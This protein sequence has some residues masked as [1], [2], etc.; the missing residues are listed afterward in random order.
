MATE[1]LS[2]ELEAKVGK[3]K[4]DLLAAQKALLKLENEALKTGGANKKMAAQIALAKNQVKLARNEYN[5]S[6]IALKQHAIQQI[7]TAGA[8]NKGSKSMKRQNMAMTQAAYAVDDMQYGFQGVQ[9]NIQ[10]MAVSMGA[11]GPLIMGLTLLVVGIGVL[12]K[13]FEKARREAKKFKESLAEKQGLMATTLR[14]AE[15]VKTAAKGSIAYKE[16][17]DILKKQGFD[18]TKESLEQYTDALAKHMIMQ[19]K[20]EANADKIKGILVERQEAFETLTRVTEKPIEFSAMGAGTG[21]QGMT[22]EQLK[23]ANAAAI[24]NAKKALDE[25]DE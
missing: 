21:S 22:I 4:S 16:S 3:Y 20:L 7:K 1:K 9:N 23:A 2:I 15:V 11:G 18:S 5:M 25:I 13:R 19:A 12:A 24:V 10:A 17:L 8:V 6:T 14:H